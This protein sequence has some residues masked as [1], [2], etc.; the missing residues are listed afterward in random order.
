M[1]ALTAALLCA[2]ALIYP[3]TLYPLI[4][5]KI[6]R[7]KTKDVWTKHT[8]S[9]EKYALFFCA[10]NE[11][12]SIK[13][14]IQNL[15]LLKENYPSL[16]FFAYD[17]NSTDG[18]AEYIE[19]HAPFV[20]LFKNRGR[21]GKAFGM[22]LLASQTTRDYL[23]FTDANVLL[24]KDA[25]RYLEHC[26]TDPVIGGVCGKLIYLGEGETT[27]SKVGGSYWKLEEKIKTLESATGSVMGADGSIFSIRRSLYPDFPDTVLDDF[28]VSMEVVFHGSRLIKC[29]EV[30][31]YERLISRRTDEFKR[32]IRIA[33]RAFHTHLFLKNRCRK[34]STIDKFKYT[35]HKTLRWFGGLSLVLCIIFFLTALILTNELLAVTFGTT[36]LILYIVSIRFDLGVISSIAEISLAMIATQLGV[37]RAINGHT[38]A[39][40]NPSTSR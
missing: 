17:D 33:T 7:G 40:W 23:I 13:E 21:N 8:T 16:E 10:F 12:H 14:K 34:L 26:Y 5:A 19:E 28:T 9:G 35:S 31:A 27:T 11:M 22:K 24:D 36:G 39:I 6:T 18:T 2:V 29:D 32:K 15:R 1:V 38:V 20:R 30:L 3:Y 4:L 37:L 25:L